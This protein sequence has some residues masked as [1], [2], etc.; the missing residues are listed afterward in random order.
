LATCALPNDWSRQH[1]ITTPSSGTRA[2]K[3]PTTSRAKG[4]I[5]VNNTTPLNAA[6]QYAGMGL[7]VFPIKPGLKTPATPHG[8][9]DASTD[10]EVIRSLFN[11]PKINIAIATGEVSGT[12]VIDLDTYADGTVAPLEAE[13]GTLPETLEATTRAGGRHLYY[14]YPVGRNIGSYNGKLAPH[15]DVK[16]NGGYVVAAPSF[17]E[18]DHKGPAGYYVWAN[19][20]P[21]AELPAAWIDHL[22]SLSTA[23]KPV[24]DPFAAASPFASKGGNLS[25]LDMGMDES[26]ANIARVEQALLHIPSSV[27]AGCDRDMYLRVIWAV[28]ATGFSGA[29]GMARVWCQ[30]SPEDFDEAAFERDFNSYDGRAGGIGVGTLFHIAEKFGYVEVT[31]EGEAAPQLLLP[32]PD[33][34][35]PDPQPIDLPIPDVKPFSTG[36]L[37]K[38]FAAY[39]DDQADLMQSPADYVAVPLMIAAAAALGNRIAIAP[40]ELDTSWVVV[41]VLWGG[42]VGRPSTMKSPSMS[43]ALSPLSLIENDMATAF[44]TKRQ[45]YA[46][47]KMLYEVEYDKAKKEIKSGVAGAVLP[48]EPDEP[49]P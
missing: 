32:L 2:R 19:D 29:K 47:E 9:C 14:S 41:P 24:T 33:G 12:A 48:P 27:S 49:K 20:L 25:D 17:V 34:G 37:P 11:S 30:V 22:E 39:V 6:L 38:S 46:T 10:P 5:N 15:V 3:S 31:P 43:R 4:Q 23:P 1:Q 18:A 16:A 36:L 35:W 7:S 42:I 40:K 21:M 45:Q 26:P 8:F 44:E 13:L 28:A